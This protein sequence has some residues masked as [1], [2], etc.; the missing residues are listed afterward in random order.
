MAR[1]FKCRFTSRQLDVLKIVVPNLFFI[2]KSHNLAEEMY[3]F[4]FLIWIFHS[5][6]VQRQPLAHL[7][8]FDGLDFI[9]YKCVAFCANRDYALVQLCFVKSFSK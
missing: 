9:L 5:K 4:N 2:E 6:P 7:C 8:R 3:N 1:S